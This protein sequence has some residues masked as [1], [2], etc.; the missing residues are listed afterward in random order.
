MSIGRALCEPPEGADYTDFI[1]EAAD[2]LAAS[3]AFVRECE[4][5][6]GQ[7]HI[8]AREAVEHVFDLPHLNKWRVPAVLD[9]LREYGA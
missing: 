1:T 2:K 4:E 6:G 3:P 5:E 8:A 9:L 7:P